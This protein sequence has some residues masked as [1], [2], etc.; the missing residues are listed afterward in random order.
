MVEAVGPV[1]P[2]LSDLNQTAAVIYFGQVILVGADF[3][4]GVQARIFNG[5]RRLS[6]KQ[7]RRV[8]KDCRKGSFSAEK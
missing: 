1:Q 4:A 5:D 8:R 6:G 2:G 3:Q 7:S